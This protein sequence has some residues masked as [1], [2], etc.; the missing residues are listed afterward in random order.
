MIEIVNSACLMYNIFEDKFYALSQQY[1]EGMSKT[2]FNG[3]YK[4]IESEDSSKHYICTEKHTDING[5]ILSWM[6]DYKVEQLC[7][8]PIKVQRELFFKRHSFIDNHY[9]DGYIY[10]PVDKIVDSMKNINDI[11]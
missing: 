10:L 11:I 7:L 1:P 3:W 2:P 6:F 9:A 8:V 5:K 4:V